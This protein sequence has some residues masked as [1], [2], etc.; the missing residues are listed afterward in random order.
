MSDN[1]DLSHQKTGKSKFRI[2][3]KIPKTVALTVMGV[4]LFVVGTLMMLYSAWFQDVLVSRLMDKINAGGDT[5]L[6]IGSLRL[7]FP[8]ELDIHDVLVV[9]HGDTLVEAST[10]QTEVSLLPLLKGEIAVRSALLEDA[11]YQMGALDSASRMIIGGNKIE[12]GSTRVKLSP[13]SIA[14]STVELDTASFDLYINPA[15]TFAVTPAAEPSPLNI[16]VEKVKFK[17]LSFGMKLM[18]TIYD[19][20]VSIKEGEIDSVKVDVLKQTVDVRQF[21]GDGMSAK[22][23]MPDSAQIASTLVIVNNDKPVSAPWTVSLGLIDIS[24]SEA[25]YTTYG[26]RPEPGLD[27]NYI[28]L[29]DISL[30]IKDFYNQASVIRMPFEVGGKERCG[31]E[32]N[33]SGTLAIDSVGIGF[34]NFHIV[35]ATGTNLKADGFIGT[36]TPLTDSSTPLRLKADGTVPVHDIE[37]MFP[38]FRPYFAGMRPGASIDLDAEI[39]GTAGNL[40][41]AKLYIRADRHITVNAHGNLKNIFEPKGLSGDVTFD[42]VVTDI[43]HWTGDLLSTAG[44]RIPSMTLNGAV[45]FENESYRAN[46]TVKTGGGRLALKGAFN[47]HGNK[48]DVQLNTSQFPVSAFMPDLGIGKASL[49]LTANG[50]G[51]D[52][53]KRATKADVEAKV[54]S[55]EYNNKEFGDIDLQASVAD[56]HASLALE[57]L[58]PGLDMHLKARGEVDDGKYIWDVTLKSNSLYLADLGLSDADTNVSADL[59]LNADIDPGM[60]NLDATLY[61]NS[62]Q[63]NTPDN[64]FS[65]DDSRIILNAGD[66]VTNVSAQNRD[67]FAY[68]SSPMPIDSIVG[69]VDL[70]SATL[71]SEFKHHE[72]DIT[73]LQKAIMPFSLNIEGGNDNILA[74]ML[75]DSNISFKRFN[76]LASNDSTL[77]LTARVTDFSTATIKTDTITFDIRQ[78]GKEIIYNATMDNNPGT[79]DQWAHVNVDGFLKDGEL[80]INLVQKNIKNQTGFDL[81]ASLTLSPDSTVTLHFEPYTPIINYRKWQL[82]KDNFVSFDFRHHHL[83]ADLNMKSDVSRIAL[84]TEHANDTVMEHHG[85]DEDLVLQL[86][87]IQL[88]DWIAL[89]PFAP[90]IKGNLSAGVRLN[91]HDNALNGN[92]TVDLEDFMYG[93]E[94][95]GDFNMDVDLLTDVKGM[96][97]ADAGLWVNG[98]KAVTLEGVLNDSTATSPFNL[99]LSMIHFPLATVNPFL[100]GVARL[101]GSLNGKMDV[102]GDSGA[103]LLNGYLAFEDAEVNVNMLG[104]TLTLT[105]DTIP[106]RN[107]IVTFDKFTVKAVN[108]NPLIIDGTVNLKSITSP[109]I[110]INVSADNMEV[111]NTNRPKKGADIYGKAFVGLKSTVRGNLNVLNVDATVDILP[112]TNVTYVLAQGT[113]AIESQAAGNMVKFINFADTAAVAAADSLKIEGTVLN[114]TAKLN[115]QTGSILSVDLGTNAQDKVQLQG[116]GNFTYVSSPVGDGRLTGRYTFSGGF[117][118]YA[119]PL[120]SNINFGFTEGSYVSFTGDIL[121]PRLNIKAVEKMKANVSQAGQNSRLIYF[122]II[123]SVSGTFD[124]MNVSF[125]LETDDDVTVAN[126][127]ASMSPTQRESEAMNLLLYNTYTGGSTKATSNLNGNPLFSF[128]TNSVNSWLA[129][130]V[131][132]VD[133]TIGVNQYDQTTNGSTSTTT[134][135][136]YQVSK[137]LFNDRIK[138]IVGGSYSDDPNEN[139]NVAENLINDISVEYYLN[140]NRTMYLRLFRHTGYESILEG[141]ITQT[142]VGFVY[143]KKI[144]RLSDMFIPRR[145]RRRTPSPKVENK[146]DQAE[147]PDVTPQVIKDENETENK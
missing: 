133:L 129:N 145:F 73:A 24:N 65:I 7:R 99:D 54:T 74:E 51:F 46:L 13:M 138:I 11:R 56:L 47:G 118:K 93:K 134:S 61:I 4:L 71:E 124:T 115:I 97:K 32:L 80:G 81:G 48:Y 44:V 142:G 122:D 95:V 79:F 123:L 110:N 37:L 100:P 102:T 28:E 60:K 35:T 135:Y 58:R 72:I 50:E 92:A 87:D 94:K 101:S 120:I 62:L 5:E 137:T 108:D 68:F 146:P 112:G 8:L 121:N 25:L 91:W 75:R 12:V 132:G 43:S 113:S 59:R 117:I 42:G 147:A 126:E 64:E 27:F 89:N 88:Q 105:R 128:L 103:P 109:E 76:V 111:V 10:V 139:G 17:S 33:A 15:D 86:F 53:F 130:N 77:Y 67:L 1:A 131:R 36:V 29:G 69:R 125:D 52:L 106:I 14:V 136:S 96:I 49:S 82:N 20:A 143:R 107:N 127:L 19:L 57:S 141:E 144:S 41:I 9:N 18:P 26:A 140:N 2:L 22:Y 85:A 23:L 38:T 116:S 119:P 63:Y 114:L 66:S 84:Y 34:E 31:L 55:V 83:D 6:K 16:D 30:R 40:D 21:I 78:E 3:K 70:V 45:R 104:S 98:Q 90:P 39:G